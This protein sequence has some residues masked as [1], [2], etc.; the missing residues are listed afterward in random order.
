MLDDGE[1]L[2]VC[3]GVEHIYQDTYITIVGSVWHIP[4]VQEKLRF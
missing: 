4:L 3:V 2:F 1:L